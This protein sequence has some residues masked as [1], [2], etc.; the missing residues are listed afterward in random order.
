LAQQYPQASEKVV[1]DGAECVGIALAAFEI[2][3]AEVA[4]GLHVTEHGLD[5]GAAP[6]LAFDD[7]GRFGKRL[8]RTGQGA[9]RE[10]ARGYSSFR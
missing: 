8:S 3:A 6:E 10:I 9:T 5:R 4:I 7:A 2:R 1:A